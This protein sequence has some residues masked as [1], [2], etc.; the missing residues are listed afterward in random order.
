MV[1]SHQGLIN[2]WGEEAEISKSG[3][4]SPPPRA[5]SIPPL[6]QLMKFK[7]AHPS[8]PPRAGHYFHTS[9]FALPL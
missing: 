2:R 7:R 8:P 1:E 9:R 3:L 5:R 4:S 6:A